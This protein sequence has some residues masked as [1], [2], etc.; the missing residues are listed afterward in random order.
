MPGLDASTH[1]EM[2]RRPKGIALHGDIHHCP[3]VHDQHS[4]LRRQIVMLAKRFHPGFNTA[5]QE[6]SPACVI[7]SGIDCILVPSR[8]SRAASSGLA[9]VAMKNDQRHWSQQ[10][11]N[12]RERRVKRM[13]WQIETPSDR[14]ILPHAGLV[15]SCPSGNVETLS[16][17]RNLFCGHRRQGSPSQFVSRVQSRPNQWA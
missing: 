17:P 8:S 9:A 2:I 13:R 15:I 4:K 6:N 12:R 5:F 11:D 1:L 3:E 14:S 7:S 16:V 10:R